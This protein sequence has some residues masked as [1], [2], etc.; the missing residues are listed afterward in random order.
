MRLRLTSIRLIEDGEQ[1]AGWNFEV[2][3]IEFYPSPIKWNASHAHCRLL[4][5][6][7]NRSTSAVQCLSLPSISFT[8]LSFRKGIRRSM[9]FILNEPVIN[10]VS[11]SLFLFSIVLGEVMGVL[12]KVFRM[13]DL[14]WQIGESCVAIVHKQT[15]VFIRIYRTWGASTRL[16]CVC[17][18]SFRRVLCNSKMYGSIT[19]LDEIV[20]EWRGTSDCRPF[21]LPG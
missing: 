10:M 2:E 15:C 20:A 13:C 6:G 21:E 14:H 18:S 4:F 12:C 11:P 7:R 16:T 1:Q 17:C 5:V 8:Y 9:N 3:M 19:R